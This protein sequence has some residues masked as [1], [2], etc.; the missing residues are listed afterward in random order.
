MMNRLLVIL[1]LT[2]PG[3]APGQTS[4]PEFARVE[5]IAGNGS[6]GAPIDGPALQVPLSNPFGIHSLPDGGLV[7]V[8]FDRH[9]VMRLD[10]QFEKLQ[11]IAGTGQKGFSPEP[12]R[13]ALHVRMNGPHEVQ[14]DSA[15]NIFVAD[16]FNHRV[17]KIDHVSGA[18]TTIAGTGQPGFSGD[19]GPGNVATFNQ[20]YSIAL[21]GNEL[22]I[23]DLQNQR[24]RKL[25]LE[26]GIVRTVCG[27]GKRKMPTDGAIAA[28]QPLAGPRSLAV[29]SQN[30]WIVLREGNSVW[31]IDRKT[32]KIH[33]VAG[34]GKRG[35]TG[36]GGPAVQ[37]RLAG[38]KGIAVEPGKAIYI[39][40]TENHAIRKV[41]MRSGIISTVIGGTGKKGFDGDGGQV[42]RRKLARPHGVFLMPNG[43]LLIGDS[44]NHRLR[45]LVRRKDEAN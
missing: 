8:S 41:D 33:H 29:D 11:V 27:T 39:A 18:W 26:S 20:A 30:I 7:V 28:K 9:V 21:D 38:P 23:A 5:T 24:I 35:F 40:D 36:D 12:N 10:P 42:Q 13:S 2:F 3:I 44:E 37:A 16:T 19:D 34:T 15:G 43:D 17:G 31:K 45:R 14:V 1:A 4:T 25:D 6:P 32:G 22:F